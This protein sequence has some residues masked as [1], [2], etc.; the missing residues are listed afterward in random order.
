MRANYWIA[1][2]LFKRLRLSWSCILYTIWSRIWSSICPWIIPPPWWIGLKTRMWRIWNWHWWSQRRIW[3]CWMKLFSL[4]IPTPRIMF[5]RHLWWFIIIW[6]IS[7]LGLVLFQIFSQ[8][9]IKTGLRLLPS[10]LKR[11]LPPWI[12]QR[13]DFIFPERPW[14]EP[15]WPVWATSLAYLVPV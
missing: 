2:H 12:L 7:M 11:S 1:F 9:F 8:K 13:S 14:S 15:A 5:R 6:P 3:C 4:L 10:C